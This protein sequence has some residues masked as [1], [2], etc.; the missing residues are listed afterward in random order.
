[1]YPQDKQGFHAE[2]LARLGEQQLRA[3]NAEAAVELL[4][5][6]MSLEPNV[7]RYH[8]LMALALINLKRYRAAEHEAKL[9][10]QLEP[11]LF[12]LLALGL[13]QLAAGR[14]ESAVQLL[15]QCLREE[16]SNPTIWASLASA[17][18]G[19]ER[20]CDCEMAAQRALRIEP[21]NLL[22][23]QALAYSLWHQG[24]YA[25]AERLALQGLAQNPED[26]MMHTLKGLAELRR[27][28]AGAAITHSLNALAV[29]PDNTDAK[30]LLL[31]A[32]AQQHLWMRPFVHLTLWFARFTA[33]TRAAI[34]IG[35]YVL[36]N[37]LIDVLQRN[38][39]HVPHL[40]VLTL[41]LTGV[42]LLAITY[43]IVAPSI[44]NGIVAR[45]REAWIREAGKRVRL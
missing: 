45:A 17:Y 13:S 33:F 27:K 32:Y 9:A 6:A 36:I 31:L 21:Q 14:Y 22:A 10:L 40:Q 30:R 23:L 29:E 24:R 7:G 2:R 18:L 37:L 11:D 15:L 35:T 41:C 1:M 16:P 5:K 42:Y 4:R 26:D 19:L 20:Y 44:F 39:T 8:G 3:G 12:A 43:L 25:E 38:S 34:V 28:N